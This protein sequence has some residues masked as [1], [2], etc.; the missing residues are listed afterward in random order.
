MAVKGDGMTRV[1]GED[2]RGTQRCTGDRESTGGSPSSKR[3]AGEPLLELVG[4][5]RRMEPSSQCRAAVRRD[6]G[7]QPSECASR[8]RSLE[9]V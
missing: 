9:Q 4:P 5:P 7:G 2:D 3:C 1:N 8:G 6:A